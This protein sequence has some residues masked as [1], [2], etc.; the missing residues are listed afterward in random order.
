[1]IKNQSIKTIKTIF[2]DGGDVLVKKIVNI[3]KQISNYL[4]IS[5]DLYHQKEKELIKTDKDIPQAWRDIATLEKEINYFRMFSGK[6]LKHLNLDV[7]EETVE[8]MAMCHVKRCYVP[9]EGAREILDYLS[10]KYQLGIISNC[11]VSRKYFELK[12]FDLEK[13]FDEVVLSREIDVDKPDPRIYKYALK[14]AGRQPE[15]CAFIDNKVENLQA[16]LDL[17]FGKVVLFPKEDYEGADFPAI[18]SLAELK[19]TF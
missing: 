14:K 5:L 4:D 1:M 17:G 11:L 2:F 6:L 13:Y 3:N 19:V 7:K 9:V 12:D 15:E 10:Q 18:D 16:V 8:Y